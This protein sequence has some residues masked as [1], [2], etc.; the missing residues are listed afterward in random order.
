LSGVEDSERR[1]IT[2]AWNIL[3]QRFLGYESYLREKGDR[4]RRRLGLANLVQ[5]TQ[6]QLENIKGLMTLL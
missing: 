1:E 5:S 2:Q 4:D 3:Q 6:A